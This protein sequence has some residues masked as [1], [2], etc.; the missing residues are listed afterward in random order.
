MRIK[1]LNQLVC[2]DCHI[3]LKSS[4]H[5]KRKERVVG[6]ELW[7]EMCN[8]KFPIRD[9]IACFIS[10]CRKPA[11]TK[12]WSL[13]KITLEQ[14]IPKKWMNFFSKE[15]LEA[16]KK[17][18]QWMISAIK[19]SKRAIHLDFATGTG[20]FLRNIV[21]ITKGEIVALEKDYPTCL[22]LR[23]FLKKIKKY[24]K[25]SIV[26]CDAKNMPFKDGV[27]DSI[28]SWHGLDEP[29]MNKTLKEVRRVLKEGGCFVASGIHYLKNSKSFLRAKKH[30]ISFLTKEMIIKALKNA[31]FKN[32]KHT[33]FF[34]GRWN[35]KNSYLP[36]FN[37][38]YIS[39]GIKSQK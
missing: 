35:E 7:C 9:E 27:F 12:V 4:I 20:R 13:R 8:K 11:K 26:C 37:D 16:L 29:E 2:P 17:E 28:S 14:E 19:K 25:V 15:E 31:G 22:E 36:V 23:Y 3:I 24:G 34:E 21:S 5:K 18:W 1:I 33:V 10:S 30:N 38:W 6:G 32:I 39:Y